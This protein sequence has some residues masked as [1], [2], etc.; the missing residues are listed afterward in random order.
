MKGD[1]KRTFRIRINV[2]NTAFEDDET[3]EILR[4]LRCIYRNDILESALDIGGH[5]ILDINGNTV[6]E[7][8]VEETR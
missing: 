3:L 6:G 4:I 7:A 8:K 2:E 1:T 5:Q